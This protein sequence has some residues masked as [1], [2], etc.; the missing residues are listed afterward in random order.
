MG[1]FLLERAR[2]EG[3]VPAPPPPA[4]GENQN[5]ILMGRDEAGNLSQVLV[6]VISGEQG[7]YSLYTLPARTLVEAPGYGFQRLDK[8]PELGGQPLL[9]QTVANLLQ[10]PIRYHITF[11]YG[12]TQFIL[13]EAG[14]INFRTDRLLSSADGTVSLAAGDNPAGS[15]RVLAYLKSSAGDFKAGPQV[16]A[17]F[18]QGLHGALTG[19]PEL[20]RRTFATQLYG[21]IRSDL[22]DE[23]FIDLLVSMTDPA[24]PFGVWALPVRVAGTG[25]SWYFEPQLDALSV[26]LSGS[27]IDSTFT[28]EVRNG[29]ADQA[30]VD[31]VTA[32]LAPLRFNM[33]PSTDQSGVGYDFTQIRCGSDALAQG[34]QVH[35]L[36]GKG[37]IIK[38]EYLEKRQIIVII[39]KDLG[40][41]DLQR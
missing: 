26:L 14:T 25:P 7:G 34:T 12:A 9:D 5:I 3:A 32:R 10:L 16:Q 37:T 2:S 31:A 17:L 8:L 24:E 20:D 22:G 40:L 33:A 11:D 23:D 15:E 36:L 28:L 30:M 41:Q 21:R 27:P 29:A 4:L 39:G 1:I 38:D 35:D 19:K 6:L 18:Y 13:E